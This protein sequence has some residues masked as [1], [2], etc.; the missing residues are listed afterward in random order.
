MSLEA[1]GDFVI[2]LSVE[3]FPNFF[4]NSPDLAPRW[5]ENYRSVE[6]KEGDFSFKSGRL[7]K[8][9]VPKPRVVRSSRT[10]GTTQ[11]IG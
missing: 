4:Y 3:F 10:R 5:W 6:L 11:D 9:A 7:C 1:Q 8:L 2:M